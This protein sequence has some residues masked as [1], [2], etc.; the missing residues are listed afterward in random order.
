MRIAIIQ[1]PGSNCERETALAVKRAGMQAVNFLWNQ[2]KEDLLQMD[3]FI[4]VGGFSYEDRSRSGI[5]AALDPVLQIVRQESEKGKPVLGICNGAQILVESGMVPGLSADELGAALTDNKQIV[6][7]KIQGTGFYNAWVQMRIAAHSSQ[8]AFTRHIKPTQIFRLPVAHGEGRF[9]ISDDLLNEMRSKGLIAFQYCDTD[10]HL[11]SEFP[12]N[13]NGSVENIAAITNASGNVM[14]MMPHP[15][16]VAECDAIF[17]SMREYIEEGCRRNEMTLHY[18][19]PAVTVRDYALSPNAQELIVELNITDNHAMSVNQ[20]LKRMQQPFQVKR[21]I[22]WEIQCDA[23]DIF[24]QVI[25]SGVLFNPRKEVHFTVRPLCPQPNKRMLIRAKE[26]MQG[27]Q[28]KQILENHFGI[29]GVQAVTQ[30]ILWQLD[31][32]HQE[33]ELSLEL[34]QS[35]LLFN[36]YSHDYYNYE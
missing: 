32:D 15:E 34:M 11:Q 16:R 14:A 3:G 25:A 13:P 17:H 24:H 36:R 33:V 29:K 7:G 31:A 9:I 4:I 10:G 18:M 35:H 27:Q 28:K 19:P 23:T 22:H 5:I 2:A 21:Q 30:G 8:N 20:A 26:D 1:F 12:V 6:N